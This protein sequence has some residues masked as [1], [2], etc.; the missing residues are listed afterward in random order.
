MKEIKNESVHT[1]DP[2]YIK[3]KNRD[4]SCMVVTWLL[5]AGASNWEGEQGGLWATGNAISR[6]VFK[7]V[8]S[9]QE[10]PSNSTLTICV[11]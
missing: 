6:S 4:N 9:L 8:C 1:R 7:W 5:P 11:H 2:I 10:N 3:N